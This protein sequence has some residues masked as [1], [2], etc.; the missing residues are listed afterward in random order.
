[1]CSFTP[2]RL[3]RFST[4]Q[5]AENSSSS[6]RTP[7]KSTRACFS[8]L[9]RAENSSM[10]TGVVLLVNRDTFQYSSA[11]RKFLN[12]SV[13]ASSRTTVSVSVLFSEPKIPQRRMG[14][15]DTAS[16]SAVSVLFSEPKIPQ[17]TSTVLAF[18]ADAVSVL[19]SEPKIPQPPLPLVAVTPG[20]RFS[21]LQRAENSSN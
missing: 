11:S 12:S 5:R 4:L 1:M 16:E 17:S 2:R 7:P 6:R 8:T 20:G 21:T 13:F 9:Q 19:F 10:Q 18:A 3:E 15:A 14:Q